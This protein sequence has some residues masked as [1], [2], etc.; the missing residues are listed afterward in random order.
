MPTPQFYYEPT[1]KED[2]FQVLID[3]TETDTRQHLGFTYETSGSGW[4]ADW[5]G[6]NGEPIAMP[7]FMN[8]LA[9]AEALYWFATPVQAFTSRPAGAQVATI[10]E[11][12]ADGSAC[13]CCLRNGCG[14]EGTDRVLQRYS[15][16]SSVE[17]SPSLLPQHGVLISLMPFGN[18][19]FMVDL[20]TRGFGRGIGYLQQRDD[21]GY[22]VLREHLIAGSVSDPWTGL[23]EVIQHHTG[24]ANYRQL[25]AGFQPADPKPG[26]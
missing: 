25:L 21:G 10:D 7:G 14:C 16:A 19:D 6:R 26:A 8:Q 15:V 20:N 24:T 13:G 3:G 18:G 17:L 9:A 22:D 5:T 1:A 2:H 11:L 23:W 12:K 4:V